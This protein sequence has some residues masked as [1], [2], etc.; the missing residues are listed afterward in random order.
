MSSVL[1]TTS[2]L[3]LPLPSWTIW[4]LFQWRLN[5][6]HRV[7]VGMPGRWQG[8]ALDVP[9]QPWQPWQLKPGD[10]EFRSWAGLRYRV[11]HGRQRA[12]WWIADPFHAGGDDRCPGNQ[13]YLLLLIFQLESENMGLHGH[14]NSF[15]WNLHFDT[16]IPHPCQHLRGIFSHHGPGLWNRHHVFGLSLHRRL[17]GAHAESRPVVHGAGG[18]AV[19]FCWFFGASV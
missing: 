3:Q 2:G 1:P 10:L 7:A 19:A 15:W 16:P 5:D 9:W 13:H 11:R 8:R 12:H 4:P 17:I 6:P 18:T 14:P